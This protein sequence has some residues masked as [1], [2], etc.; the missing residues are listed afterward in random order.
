MKTLYTILLAFIFL[1]NAVMANDEVEK[2][3]SIRGHVRSSDGK[4][5]AYVTVG[6]KSTNKTTMTDEEGNFRLSG[7]KPGTYTLH[8][9][10]VGLA[11]E[12]QQV[13]ITEGKQTEIT[14]ILHEN[15]AQLNEVV[16]STSHRH[17]R[18]VKVGKSGLRPLDI[19]QS[20]Q[21]ID[22]TVIADQQ[23]NRLTDVMKNVGE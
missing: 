14:V 16:V 18:P 17:N 23:I 8:I 9:S 13:V 15:A 5:A 21:V 10:H 22:S 12:E 1:S 3:G 6:L 20:I 7:I 11:T 2:N 4:P 19:P